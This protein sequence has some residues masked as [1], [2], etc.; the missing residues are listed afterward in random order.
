MTMTDLVLARR[1]NRQRAMPDRQHAEML[2]T[3]VINDATRQ[4]WRT[5]DL[6][7]DDDSLPTPRLV[8]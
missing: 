8:A 6:L 5:N 3:T 2:A 7:S 1:G 4:Q